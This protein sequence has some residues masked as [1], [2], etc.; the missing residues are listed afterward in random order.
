MREALRRIDAVHELVRRHPGELALATDAAE[1]RAAAAQGRI[2]CLM[3]IEGGHIIE[4][5]LAGAAQ[6]LPA[7]ASAT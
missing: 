2:A 4:D 5:R 3:G 6:L 7:R 1:I